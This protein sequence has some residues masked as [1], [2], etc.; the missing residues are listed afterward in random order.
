MLSLYII[1]FFPLEIYSYS[2]GAAIR[3]V[4]VD[5][6]GQCDAIRSTKKRCFKF[7]ETPKKQ[8]SQLSVVMRS[9]I[10][11]LPKKKIRKD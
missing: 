1:I 8:S 10:L 6:Y 2:R 9:W 7:L 3:G 4:T 11:R 5:H